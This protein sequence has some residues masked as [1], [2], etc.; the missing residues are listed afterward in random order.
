MSVQIVD[1]LI[2]V[3]CVA[4]TLQDDTMQ[5]TK[6]YFI[7]YLFQLAGEA[8]QLPLQSSLFFALY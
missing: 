4:I 7:S 3:K 2:G 5:L 1:S 8:E 6:R